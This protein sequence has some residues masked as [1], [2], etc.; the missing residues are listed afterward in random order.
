MTIRTAS[1]ADA[2]V[3]AA[4]EA[5]CFGEPWTQAAL[6]SALCDEKYLILVG[7]IEAGAEKIAVG[8]IAGWSVGDEAELARVA[9]IAARRGAGLGEL[10]LR[11]FIEQ[12]RSRRVR[13]IFLEVRVGNQIAKRLYER[14]GFETVGRRPQYYADGEDALV[15]RLAI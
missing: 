1:P 11:A 9:V 10:L 3:L 4:L 6:S 12:T 2:G 13:E 14:C 7:E 15:M 5:A 8:Y